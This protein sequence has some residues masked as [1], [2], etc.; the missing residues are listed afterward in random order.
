MRHTVS[1]DDLAARSY[2]VT[3]PSGAVVLPHQ[4]GWD[5]LLYATSGLMRAETGA[6]VWVVPP[7]R[8]LWLP[9]G[10]SGVVR[11][12]GR[13]A[14]RTLYLRSA[15]LLPPRTLAVDVPP[16]LRELILHAVRSCPLERARADHQR[17]VDMIGDQLAVAPHPPLQLPLP[18]DGRALRLAR[19]MMAN[20]EQAG[21]LNRLAAGV[22]ASRRTLE[23]LF[24]AETGMTIGQWRGRLRLVLAVEQLAA[25]RPVTAVASAVG[26]ATPSAFTAMFRAQLGDP[27]RRYLELSRDRRA[28]SA[29]ARPR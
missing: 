18:H 19:A 13:V 15:G 24:L 9:D 16:L 8:A 20:P 27:P 14:V 3:H 17:I 7:H 1:D 25:G 11:M 29:A 21:A 28:A 12:Q 4:P 6:E 23:R 10:V 22:G 26:Y 5:Q 2:A